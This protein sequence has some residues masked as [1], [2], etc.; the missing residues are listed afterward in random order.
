MIITITKVM[1]GL[2]GKLYQLN[3][4]DLFLNTVGMLQ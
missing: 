4:Y 1:V 2:A 3:S